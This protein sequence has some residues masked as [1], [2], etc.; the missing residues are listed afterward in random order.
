MVCIHYSWRLSQDGHLPDGED[1]VMHFPRFLRF[2]QDCKLLYGRV[3]Q[4]RLHVLFQSV[5]KSNNDNGA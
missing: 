4:E 3:S 2:F 5:H 1:I